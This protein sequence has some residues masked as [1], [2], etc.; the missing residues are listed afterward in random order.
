MFK[1]AIVCKPGRAIING[2]TTSFIGKPIY[3][4]AFE[5]HSKYIETLESLGLRVQVLPEREMYPDSTFIEDVAL[6][7]Q[8]CAIITRPAL[9]ARRGEITGIREELKGYYDNIEEIS[10]PGT[11]EAGDVMMTGN[12]FFIG[13]SNRTNSAGADQLIDILE[14]YN[15]TASKVHLNKM[16]HLKSGVSYLENDNM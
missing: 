11:L 15:M 9:S 14:E 1:N 12:H 2:I 13:I 7:T 5:Q 16:L 4:L 3:S 10:L 6:C 8:Q